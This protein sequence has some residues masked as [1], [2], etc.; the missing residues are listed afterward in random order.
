MKDM[1]K[2]TY[3]IFKNDLCLSV[4]E[5]KLKLWSLIL[6]KKKRKTIHFYCSTQIPHHKDNM[7]EADR[8]LGPYFWQ[9]QKC[10]CVK[11]INGILTLPCCDL[12][13]ELF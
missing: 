8:C 12:Y 1:N 7:T 13:K 9:A 11:P 10:G 2:V 5:K 3:L 4:H 6:P